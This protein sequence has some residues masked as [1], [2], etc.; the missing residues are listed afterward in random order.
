ML[1]MRDYLVMTG[2]SLQKLGLP[3][4]TRLCYC[5]YAAP[6]AV[7][8]CTCDLGA[9]AANTRAKPQLT[10]VGRLFVESAKPSLHVQPRRMGLTV[11]RVA[12]QTRASRKYIDPS[13]TM[14][15]GCEPFKDLEEYHQ[16]K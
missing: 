6:L 1:L 7:P 10:T 12:G 15:K 4:E 3:S 13:R 9:V 5:S 8:G 16:R 14:K 2:S 11:L